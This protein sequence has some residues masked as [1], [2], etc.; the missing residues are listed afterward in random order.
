MISLA[1]PEGFVNPIPTDGWSC[2]DTAMALEFGT[3]VVR[4]LK[5]RTACSVTDVARGR[6]EVMRHLEHVLTHQQSEACVRLTTERDEARRQLEEVTHKLAEVRSTQCTQEA[7]RE[8]SEARL[9]KRHAETLADRDRKVRTELEAQYK[10]A[11]VAAEARTTAATHQVQ[12]HHAMVQT[13]MDEKRE[14]TAT[15]TNA[16]ER[17]RELEEKLG[18]LN[19]SSTK[20]NHK[21]SILR[22]AIE[23]VGLH[24][25]D[26]SKQPHNLFYHDVLVSTGVLVRGN[27][28]STTP[29]YKG[30]TPRLSVEWK[31]YKNGSKLTEQSQ[32]F[33]EVRQRMLDGGYAECFL[34]AATAGIPRRPRR[35]LE[36]VYIDGRV[37]VTGYVGADDVTESEILTMVEVVL[38]LQAH[39]RPKADATE[40]DARKDEIV[41]M[42]KWLSE[43]L[44]EHLS[45]CE[46][47]QKHV[48]SLSDDLKNMRRATVGMILGQLDTLSH[49]WHRTPDNT[50]LYNALSSLRDP[51]AQKKMLHPLLRTKEDAKVIQ[52]MLA[53]RKRPHS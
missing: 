8:A 43:R 9:E 22:D 35:D 16:L 28:A 6:D 37:S 46:N 33:G 5:R 51:P 25:Y 7:Q 21:E 32:K 18:Q 13:L 36:I 53:S 48:S 1:V 14:G 20:G 45:Q 4:C 44:Q 12:V 38:R 42:N 29:F 10:E 39:L 15:L 47:M 17:V 40:P 52:D 31:G 27:S 3:E 2:D 24:A 30:T 34:F 23:S 19:G 49:E 11:L 41:T 26:T 50:Q